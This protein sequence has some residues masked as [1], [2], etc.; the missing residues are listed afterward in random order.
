MNLRSKC[1]E[2]TISRARERMSL[3]AE[4]TSECAKEAEAIAEVERL[5]RGREVC[6]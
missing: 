5:E 2:E 6:A 3:L 4:R 1:E